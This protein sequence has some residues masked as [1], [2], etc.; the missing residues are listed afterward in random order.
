M[1]VDLES[2]TPFNSPG[3]N[4]LIT[5]TVPHPDDTGIQNG[6][7]TLPAQGHQNRSDP[8]EG[9]TEIAPVNIF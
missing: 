5:G 6:T 1:V 4:D 2:E 9:K 3:Q 8:E 7:P